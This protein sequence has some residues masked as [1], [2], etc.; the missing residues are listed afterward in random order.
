VEVPWGSDALVM[1]H[2]PLCKEDFCYSEKAGFAV[3]FQR[4]VQLVTFL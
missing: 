2:T 1:G 4:L 3:G